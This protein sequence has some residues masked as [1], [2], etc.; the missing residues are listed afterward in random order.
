[1][2]K[3]M[4]AVDVAQAGCGMTNTNAAFVF[5]IITICLDNVDFVFVSITAVIITLLTLPCAQEVLQFNNSHV[6][7]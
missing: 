7:Q 6:Q 1:M 2:Q 3:H 5:K 4:A